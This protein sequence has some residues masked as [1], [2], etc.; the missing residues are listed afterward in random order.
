MA[1]NPEKSR[2]GGEGVKFFQHDT[3]ARTNRKIRKVIRTHGAVGYAIWWALLEELHLADEEGWQLKADDLWLEGVAES[4]CISDCRTLVRVFDA[5]ADVG[6]ISKQL[7]EEHYLYS[8]AIVV[9]GDAYVK[10]KALHAEAQARYAEKLKTT[11]AA[12]KPARK[13]PDASAALTDASANISDYQ[14]GKTDS[15][16]P[17]A[18]PKANADP[19]SP[20]QDP[21]REDA[22]R[23]VWVGD[24]NF[25][26]PKQPAATDQKSQLTA[27]QPRTIPE[28]NPTQ[29]IS[30]VPRSIAAENAQQGTLTLSRDEILM[31][32]KRAV[33]QGRLSADERS[34]YVDQ[35]IDTYN[36][37][38]GA[39]GECVGLSNSARNSLERMLAVPGRSP[40]EFISLVRDAT[41][42]AAKSEW[43]NKPDF[44]SKHFGYLIGRSG[45]QDRLV[46][47]AF[48][49]RSLPD[50][51]KVGAALKIA[52]QKEQIQYHD[53][54]GRPLRRTWAKCLWWDIS[55]AAIAGE[56][57]SQLQKD[58]AKYYFPDFDIYVGDEW[59]GA[60][61]GK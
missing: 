10:K 8:E 56:P 11:A 26:L 60:E 18:D 28:Q 35:A 59:L 51:S 55:K 14:N 61:N 44:E 1:G 53:L 4:L 34:A 27:E 37:C 33:L 52:Q 41:L 36:Q 19:Y 30:F 2:L 22:R 39:W 57:V 42:W 13:S 50:S 45:N 23:D 20:H 24:K 17:Y 49:W 43:L 32:Q 25:D 7:W 38:R 58:W 46:D 48:Q 21:E 31:Q 54:E 47:Y 3:N 12:E 5:F 9:R 40:E 15:P 6:L 16:D 29:E